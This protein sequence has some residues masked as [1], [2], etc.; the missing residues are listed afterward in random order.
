[1]PHQRMSL[2]SEDSL[3]FLCAPLKE[4]QS[5]NAPVRVVRATVVSNVPVC[6]YGRSGSQW[7]QRGPG[8][9]GSG[10]S[11]FQRTGSRGPGHSGSSVLVRVVLVIV[12]PTYRFAWSWSQWFQRTGSRGP[13]HSGSN[14]LVRV[15][16]VTV[17]PT[18]L[19]AWSWS[20]WFQRTGSRGPGHSGSN[21]GSRGPGHSSFQRT[22]FVVRVTVAPTYRFTWSGSQEKGGNR[23][24]AKLIIMLTRNC[25]HHERMSHAQGK[26]SFPCAPRTVSE[27]FGSHINYRHWTN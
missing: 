13:G 21:T 22:G 10:Q 15:V 1:M 17:A 8:S 7:F 18:Y 9:R 12:A 4:P 3:Y 11:G 19:F 2:L 5:C 6:T 26:M 27:R 20:Q 24:C 14:V 25:I 16:L 23:C